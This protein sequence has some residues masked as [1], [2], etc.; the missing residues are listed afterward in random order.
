M[1]L[2]R[3]QLE[4]RH[5][6]TVHDVDRLARAAMHR[7]NG[8]RLDPDDRWATAW[9]SIVTTLLE[10]TEP[11]D[12]RTLL[13]TAAR[14]LNTEANAYARVW[15]MDTRRINEGTAIMGGFRRYWDWLPPPYPHPERAIEH[16]AMWQ[17]LAVL[18]AR[19]LEAIMQLAAHDGDGRAAAHAMGIT[20]GGY[21]ALLH[22]GRT[23]FYELWHEGE[24]PTV[25]WAA[26]RAG[27]KRGPMQ[28]FRYRQ[29]RRAA[30]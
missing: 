28:W 8:T 30:G 29:V 12:E 27:A 23:R 7:R 9:H 24:Q 11:P 13:L 18:P 15:G 25:R 2:P 20:W 6:Y 17:I 16:M 21:C 1:T 3:G 5:G 10:A 19:Q 14:A 4:L 26:G 22:R